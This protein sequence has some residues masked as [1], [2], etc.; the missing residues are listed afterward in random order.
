MDSVKKSI[1]PKTDKDNFGKA[2]Q[3]DHTYGVSYDKPLDV[4][5]HSSKVPQTTGPYEV[6]KTLEKKKEESK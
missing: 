4:D 1:T 5:P 3:K 2:D 6:P